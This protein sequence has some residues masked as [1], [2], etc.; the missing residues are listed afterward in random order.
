MSEWH[1][2]VLKSS[3]QQ[4]GA[5]GFSCLDHWLALSG[6]VIFKPWDGLMTSTVDIGRS[7]NTVYSARVL[8]SHLMTDCDPSHDMLHVLRVEQTARKL[9]MLEQGVDILVVALGAIF[10]DILDH[11]YCKEQ[12]AEIRL[13][14]INELLVKQELELQRIVNVLRIVKNVGFSLEKKLKESGEWSSWHETCREY[15]CVQDADRLDAIGALGIFRVAAY[16]CAKNQPLYHPDM[17]INSAYRHFYDKLLGLKDMLRT[18]AARR[19][20]EK[21]QI[22]M[23][24]LLNAANEEFQ[25]SDIF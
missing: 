7:E 2:M 10:H 18:P 20:G 15:H 17:Q 6:I 16:A 23:L 25:G 1:S 13:S 3:L 8:A 22:I 12:E 4:S 24:D 14:K 19:A 21:R 11:K 5:H 9:A